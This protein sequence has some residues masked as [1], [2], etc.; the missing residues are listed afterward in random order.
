MKTQSIAVLSITLIL[1]ALAQGKGDWQELFNGKDLKGW[2]VLNGEAEYRVENGT[3]VGVTKMNTP[4]TF[5]ATEK[6]YGNFILEI[7]FKLDADFNSGIQIRSL[8]HTNYNNGRVHGYQVEV[9]P[10]PR[11]W[12]GG[13][14]DEARRGWLYNL[15]CNPEGKKAFKR[16][17]WNRFRVEAIDSHI[18]VWLND[19]PTVDL[20]DDMTPKGFIALQVHGIKNESQAGHTV[21]W[22]RIRIMTEDVKSE[23]SPITD[24]IPQ[25]SYLTNRLTK[26]EQREGWKLLWDGRTTTGWR[27][28]RLDHFPE[29]GWA[30]RDGL[31]M[32]EKSGG[33]E[34]AHGGD[35]VTTRQ[36]RNFELELDFKLTR[37][38]NSGIK[39]FVD[40]ELNQGRGSSI[41]CEYQVLDDKVHPDAKAGAGGNRTLA[42]VYDLIK[43]D[44]SYYA[45]N[46]SSKKRVNRYGWN[47][48]KVVVRGK[49]VEHYLNGIK[50]IDYERATQTWRALVSRSKYAVWPNFGEREEGHILLQDHGDEVSFK[51]IKIK[52]LE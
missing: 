46:E 8:S 42:S 50:V 14:Y 9:D 36:Y 10:S 22:R 12:T 18:R 6:D 5:L 47:R 16:H 27:G 31:L 48:A 35:I 19:T 45:P 39:Y 21:R 25:I 11:A 2:H 29:K 20:V 52:E 41:G 43:A 38:A 26:R 28:A 7:D 24:R 33:G 17:E 13:I 44:A 37:G 4:N 34:S 15:E 32:V 23:M 49:H 3:I 1:S 40:T 30:I 51:N